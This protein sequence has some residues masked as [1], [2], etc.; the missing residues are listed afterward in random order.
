MTISPLQE[1]GWFEQEQHS[2]QGGSSA[3][4]IF[5]KVMGAI[6]G[7]PGAPSGRYQVGLYGPSA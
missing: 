7:K 6:S 4:K 1:N 5:D 2:G 3:S